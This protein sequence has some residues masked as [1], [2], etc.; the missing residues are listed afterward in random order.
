[1]RKLINLGKVAIEHI[2]LTAASAAL[3]AANYVTHLCV[4]IYLLYEPNDSRTSTLAKTLPNATGAI[5]AYE[6]KLLI[7]FACVYALISVFERS[8]RGRFSFLVPLSVFSFVHLSTALAH[9]QL[10]D[11][12]GR[13][14]ELLP[15]VID[16]L[17]P[18]TLAAGGFLF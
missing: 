11:D 9:P 10:Y 1:M 14:G 6:A 8:Y 16:R 5:V 3:V 15:L 7:V 12:I 13:V 18:R 4:S 17:R 2:R